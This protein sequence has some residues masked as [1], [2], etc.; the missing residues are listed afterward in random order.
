M[1][2]S[3]LLA[4]AILGVSFAAQTFAQ[5]GGCD[6]DTPVVTSRWKGITRSTTYGA[7]NGRA[8]LSFNAT[9]RTLWVLGY[10]NGFRM[11]LT[12][13]PKPVPANIEDAYPRNLTVGEVKCALDQF[14]A[15]PANLLISIPMA[16]KQLAMK[17]AGEEPTESLEELR[18]RAAEA[19]ERKQTDD[20]KGPK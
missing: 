3:F 13:I 11:T 14:Y 19:P 10:N 18:R 9:N 4:P 17:A 20:G 7:P 8:W 5:M 2:P 6:A 15:D 12:L 16:V 1:K